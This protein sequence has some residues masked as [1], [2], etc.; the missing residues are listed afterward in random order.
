MASSGSDSLFGYSAS[1]GSNSGNHP[2]MPME[3]TAGTAMGATAFISREQFIDASVDNFASVQPIMPTSATPALEQTRAITFGNADPFNVTAPRAK[4]VA[5]REIMDIRRISFSP[6]RSLTPRT[7]IHPKFIKH[8]PR[9]RPPSPLMIGGRSPFSPH[10]GTSSAPT[11]TDRALMDQD[12]N[13]SGTLC[14]FNEPIA[15]GLDTVPKPPH[16]VP[17]HTPESPRA[18]PPIAAPKLGEYDELREQNKKLM[19]KLGEIQREKNEMGCLI[20]LSQY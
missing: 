3:A 14:I 16:N 12:D 19:E 7:I 5:F 17:I 9:V 11:G 18:A 15:A 6:A 8:S 2:A 4:A 20:L 1:D 13:M 10:R